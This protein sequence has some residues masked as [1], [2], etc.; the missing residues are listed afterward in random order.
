MSE[1]IS[2]QSEV[3]GI[4]LIGMKGILE[5]QKES[6]KKVPQSHSECTVGRNV[7]N[8]MHKG[9][10]GQCSLKTKAKIEIHPSMVLRSRC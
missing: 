8:T 2:E 4:S 1:V 9:M 10:R 5:M 6:S 7:S 3:K